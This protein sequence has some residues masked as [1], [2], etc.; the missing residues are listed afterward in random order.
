[1]DRRHT[2]EDCREDIDGRKQGTRCGV[3]DVL[4]E[5]EVLLD[6]KLSGG[7][8]AV[9]FDPSHIKDGNYYLSL[10]ID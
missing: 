10:K 4:K 7:E 2:I 8:H 1:M 9:D 3:R 6:K 5:Q